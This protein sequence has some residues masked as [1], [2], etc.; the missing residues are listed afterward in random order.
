MRGHLTRNDTARH[1]ITEQPGD[2]ATNKRRP[3]PPSDLQTT[4]EIDHGGSYP[5]WTDERLRDVAEVYASALAKGE[6][7]TP[8]VQEELSCSYSNAAKIGL[9][10]RRAGWL[11]PTRRGEAKA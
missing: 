2:T 9:R 1:P 11:P 10:A 3:S 4:R 8:A 5:Q 6:P 7:P